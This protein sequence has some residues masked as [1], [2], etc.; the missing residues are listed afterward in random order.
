MK[1]NFINMIKVD[2]Q[3][4]CKEKSKNWNLKINSG[5]N[6]IVNQNKFKA[7]VSLLQYFVLWLSSPNLFKE[8]LHYFKRSI[9]HSFHNI[10]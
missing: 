4:P 7:P 5:K 1:R 6:H 9:F 2:G 10:A 3:K 8:Y